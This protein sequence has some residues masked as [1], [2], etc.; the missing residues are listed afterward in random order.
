MILDYIKSYL[1]IDFNDDDALLQNL[2]DQ[3]DIYIHSMVGES[4][5][6]DDK[7]LKLAEI[8]QIKLIADLYEN[9]TT[10]I[11]G[12]NNMKR[13]IIVNSILDKLALAGDDFE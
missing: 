10:N 11:N 3:T 12:A 9:R 8:L 7:L 6:K 2:I 1:H 4:Y 5:K 13:D